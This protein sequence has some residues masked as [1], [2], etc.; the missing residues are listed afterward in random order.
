MRQLA[1]IVERYIIMPVLCSEVLPGFDTAMEQVLGYKPMQE[2]AQ[3]SKGTKKLRLS[4]LSLKEFKSADC[5]L[6]LGFL[7]ACPADVELLSQMTE[8]MLSAI[9]VGNNDC[10]LVSGTLRQW[11]N[12]AKQETLLA[13]S[14]REKLKTLGV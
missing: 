1:P 13:K 2:A 6:Y 10:W 7:I 8:F 14:I 12:F 3:T 11:R 5:H 4:E 9:P